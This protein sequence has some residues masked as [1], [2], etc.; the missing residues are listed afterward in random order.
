MYTHIYI[1]IHDVIKCRRFGTKM[2]HGDCNGHAGQKFCVRHSGCRAHATHA[3]STL[4]RTILR[5]GVSW[6]AVQGS[7]P[8]PVVL[9]AT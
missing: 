8:S 4:A 5:F 1:Y 3:W 9:R 7:L 2:T 6:V